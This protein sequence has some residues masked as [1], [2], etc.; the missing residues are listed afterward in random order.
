MRLLFVLL[1]LLSLMPLSTTQEEKLPGT[2][3]LCRKQPAGM[4][5][6]VNAQRTWFREKL[7]E[8]FCQRVA[9]VYKPDALPEEVME[10][11]LAARD[12][13]KTTHVI[14]YWFTV[15]EQEK[16]FGKSFLLQGGIELKKVRDNFVK[17]EI[18]AAVTSQLATA[19][20]PGDKESLTISQSLDLLTQELVDKTMMRV[21]DLLHPQPPPQLDSTHPAPYTPQPFV[22]IPPANGNGLLWFVL[23]ILTL[24]SFATAGALFVI[25]KRLM[26]SEA[27]AQT[28]VSSPFQG[29]ART[30]YMAL[31]GKHL[32]HR[33][34]ADNSTPA[35]N[36]SRPSD[37]D[38]SEAATPRRKASLA[39]PAN[40][41]A[42]RLLTLSPYICPQCGKKLAWSE[43]VWRAPHCIPCLCKKPALSEQLGNYQLL[44]E[45]RKDTF[46]DYFLARHVQSGQQRIVHRLP[47]ARPEQRDPQQWPRMLLRFQRAQKVLQ[48]FAQS[49]QHE[50]LVPNELQENRNPVC[51]YYTIPYLPAM[52]LQEV[53]GEL[54]Q[55]K[56][57]PL[58]TVLA[59]LDWLAKVLCDLHAE[60]VV[61]REIKPERIWCH[62][63][64]GLY[65]TGFFLLKR[66]R[67]PATTAEDALE[68]L[69]WGEPL[70]SDPLT[71]GKRGLGDLVYAP[72]EQITEAAEVDDKADMWSWGVT[73][74][75]LLTGKNYFDRRSRK[76]SIS[77]ISQY[78]GLEELKKWRDC[79]RPLVEVYT[80]CTRQLGKEATIMLDETLSGTLA[81][82]ARQRMPAEV[83]LANVSRL[84][85]LAAART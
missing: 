1:V 75:E 22:V 33:Q 28:A 56:P 62:A 76:D 13:G 8:K 44:V 57:Q 51:F 38:Q 18:L 21:N 15:Q 20:V 31:S 55:H 16:N 60:G 19:D 66:Y 5:L 43:W 85:Q 40:Q 12:V 70:T 23:G 29:A 53:A 7:K 9:T 63:T 50:L 65:L 25:G 84:R 58:A 71:A 42:I 61:H 68:E 46:G 39:A 48:K 79:Q 77:A 47:A 17:G 59:V 35:T 45:I 69:G 80:L 32:R 30:V 24:L 14:F 81:K 73:A 6:P 4:T 83:V 49:Q 78:S 3:L 64:G 10:E 34:V 82:E 36:R 26:Q 67:Q 2:Y 72:L 37:I 11:D 52:T 74:C 27:Q 41:E 54:W